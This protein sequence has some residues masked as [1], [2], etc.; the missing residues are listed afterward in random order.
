MYLFYDY[1]LKSLLNSTRQQ[2][3]KLRILLDTIYKIENG[4]L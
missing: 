4:Y 3:R 1:F 2:I